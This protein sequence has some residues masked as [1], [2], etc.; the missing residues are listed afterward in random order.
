MVTLTLK[1]RDS[2]ISYYQ[3]T[4]AS[5]KPV[6]EGEKIPIGESF[7][8][9]SLLVG[10]AEELKVNFYDSSE[11]L[12]CTGIFQEETACIIAEQGGKR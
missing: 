11:S 2:E 1:P 6:A 3:I 12:L 8:Y 5:G 10:Q 9:L 7:S 4:D